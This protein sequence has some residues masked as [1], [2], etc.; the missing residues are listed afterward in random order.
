VAQ[1]FFSYSHKDETLRDQLDV[2]LAMLKR[3]G[4]VATWHDRRIVAGEPLD[5]SIDENL[6]AA[7]VILL[8]LSPDFLASDYCYDKEVA[9]A[10]QR[11]RAGLARVIPVI[12]RPCDW[13][14]GTPF[15]DLVAA[16]KDGKPVTKWPD[17]DDAF[18][19]ITNAISAAIKLDQK[20]APSIGAAAAVVDDRVAQAAIAAPPV[21]RSSNLRI[22]KIFSDQDQDRFLMDGFEYLAKFFE[23][24]LNELKAR[25]SDIDITFR[26]ADAHHFSAAVYRYGKIKTQCRIWLGGFGGSRI[27]QIMYSF[28]AAGTDHSFNEMVSVGA[29]RDSLFLRPTGGHSHRSESNGGKLTMQGA[30]EYFWAIFVEPLQQ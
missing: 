12:L 13:R 25:N 10:M 30:A 19:D 17:L 18:M 29:D 14:N 23:G 2:H 15:G 24:S 11:H 26:Q 16:P 28:N 20:R 4:I 22:S 7:D 9:R 1:V 8:L 27:S 6:D 3:Q 21:A 5:S